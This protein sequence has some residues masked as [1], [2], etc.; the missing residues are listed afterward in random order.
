MITFSSSAFSSN[1]LFLICSYS[2]RGIKALYSSSDRMYFILVIY[3]VIRLIH[4]PVLRPQIQLLP[5]QTHTLRAHQSLLH[6]HPNR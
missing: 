4:Y 1:R 3:L 5:L 6:H 2:F